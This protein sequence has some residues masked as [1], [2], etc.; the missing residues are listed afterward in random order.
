MSS[1]FPHDTEEV[2][3]SNRLFFI[4]LAQDLT[5]TPN[6]PKLTRLGCSFILDNHSQWLSIVNG[7]IYREL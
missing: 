4:P 6:P 2:S 1:S 5:L 3:S 7:C